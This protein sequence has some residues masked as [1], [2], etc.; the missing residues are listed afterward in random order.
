MQAL[1]RQLPYIFSVNQ[2][3][4]F[5]NIVKPRQQMADRRFASARAP[6]EGKGFS[7]FYMQGNIIQHGNSVPIGKADMIIEDVSF[8]ILQFFCIRCVCNFRF[9]PH[10]FNKTVKTRAP[11]CIHFHKLHQFAHRC[12]K[13]GDIQCKRQQI[14]KA[15][16][17]SH[18][19]EASD[20]DYSNLHHTD[21]CF[22]SRIKKAHSA[23]IAHF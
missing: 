23:V 21:G 10:Q 11:L 8:Y 9:C 12:Q 5:R 20:A 22:N 16:F 13:N 14:N 17:P 6:C 7:G 15:Q 2:N 19:Q 1:L 3:S 18:D 4:S